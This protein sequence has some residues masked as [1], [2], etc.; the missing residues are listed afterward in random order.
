MR[1]GRLGAWHGSA[2][3]GAIQETPIAPET[4]LRFKSVAFNK[5][6]DASGE[7]ERTIVPSAEK[8][9]AGTLASLGHRYLPPIPLRSLGLQQPISQHMLCMP[10]TVVLLQAS[11]RDERPK[12]PASQGPQRYPEA[13]VRPCLGKCPDCRNFAT[14]TRRERSYIPHVG[15][16]SDSP[17]R[18]TNCSGNPA[19]FQKCCFQQRIRRIR[20]VR[21]NYRPGSLGLQQPISQHMLCMPPTVVLL[22]ASQRDERP[23]KPASQGPQRYPEALVQCP[24]CRNFATPTRRGKELYPSCRNT[25]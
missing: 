21:K 23:K 20:R 19:A 15:I 5:E 25:E 1:E 7:S 12:K 11:Q 17:V 2:W 18:R 8:V 10:P 4:L 3:P 13:L 9:A 16:R 22:Q 24:D 6:S 14:P